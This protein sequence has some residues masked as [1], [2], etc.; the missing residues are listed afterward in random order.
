MDATDIKGTLNTEKNE[1]SSSSLF[2]QIIFNFPHLGV[3]DLRAH[4][5]LLSH[6]FDSARKCLKNTPEAAVHVALT[7]DQAKAWKLET[8][9]ALAK[10]RVA[11]AVP[12][13]PRE[14]NGYECKR[15]QVFFIL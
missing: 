5:Y 6:F 12:F 15:H 10:L 9:A 7:L 8:Q 14:W 11:S 3:E 4:Q 1:A 2:D 13:D